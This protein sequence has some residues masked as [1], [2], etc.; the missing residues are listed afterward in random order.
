MGLYRTKNNR[1]TM[2]K[3]SSMVVV[4]WVFD[5][6]VG[7]YILGSNYYD[8]FS[9]IGDSIALTQEKDSEENIYNEFLNVPLVS[10][11]VAGAYKFSAQCLDVQ[12][13]VL[14]NLFGAKTGVHPSTG[15]AV[16]G[17]SVIPAD[18]QELYALVKITFHDTGTPC[19]IIPKLHLNSSLYL[20]QLQS[21]GTQCNL[22]GV[23]KN[24]RVAVL[25]T[26]IPDDSQGYAPLVG[27]RD[28]RTLNMEYT[29][30]TSVLF[31]P[32]AANYVVTT[33]HSTDDALGYDV[34][35]KTN[36]ST[37]VTQASVHIVKDSSSYSQ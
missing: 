20:Q 24:V 37:G 17:L 23:A 18:Y 28:P 21:R 16:Q 3:A 26:T 35:S 13:T 2:R 10:N 36:F 27:F 8:I 33:Y 12:N 11:T 14:A 6:T 5:A 9:V 4:P 15:S 7:D 32:H 19:V 34:Y 22:A 1:I 25:D 29:P 30:L 31:L